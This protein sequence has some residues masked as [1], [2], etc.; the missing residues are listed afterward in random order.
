L[1]AAAL[2]VLA[3]GVLIA[4]ALVWTGPRGSAALGGRG[5]HGGGAGGAA[6]AAP[7]PLAPDLLPPAA[8]A[9]SPTTAA[10]LGPPASVSP[11]PS[12][13]PSPTLPA[14]SAAPTA[15]VPAGALA[16]Y[17]LPAP[18][19]GG[20]SRWANVWVYTPAGYETSNSRYPVLY[21]V[22]WGA[23]G[24]EAAIHV[25]GLL[26]ALIA[27]GTLW[28]SVVV[29]VNQA[30]GPYR[31]SECADSWDGRE[32]FDTFVAS[33]VVAWVDA[34][35]RTLRTPLARTLIGFS[36]GGYCA[37]TLLFHHP[38]VFGN[39]V[40]FSG[41]YVAGIWSPETRLA[42]RPFGGDA[43]LIADD[44]P[45]VLAGRL[46]RAV[47]RS[48]FLVLV[49]TPGEPF[50]GPQ[51]TSFA[52]ALSAGGYPFVELDSVRGHSWAQVRAMLPSALQALTQHQRQAGLFTPPGG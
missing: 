46:P 22:P 17:E 30:G 11:A 34:H 29:F 31:P 51:L 24:W 23:D 32:H 2:A 50:F 20:T 35:F 12:A 19:V 5:G 41:Y 40:S 18:W 49:G 14:R 7:R 39:A 10:S 15:A 3:C 33:T 26:D 28:P 43:S 38:D 44:S 42:Y 27:D 9:P 6:L 36:Q 37:P 16:Q 4:L 13:T 1:A 48:L 8:T 21:E 25:R 47:R 45:L 52:A